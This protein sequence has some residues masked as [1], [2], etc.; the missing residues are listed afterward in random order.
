VGK[1]ECFTGNVLVAWNTT[2]EVAQPE[3]NLN[4]GDI[5]D[6]G[7][8]T[9]LYKGNANSALHSNLLSNETYYYSVW[10]ILN[11][12]Y[13]SPLSFAAKTRCADDIITLPY[14]DTIGPF[15][16]SGCTLDTMSFR[17]FTAGPQPELK[18]VE[19][20]INP[21]AIPFTGGYMLQFNAYDT[22]ET[23]EVWLTTGHL[24]SKG[25]AS[26]DV[27]FK[28]YEDASDYTGEFF[29]PEGVTLQWSVDYVNW[30]HVVR[31]PRITEYGNDGWKYKQVTL[32]SAAANSDA[33][34]IRFVFTSAWGFNCYLDEI[35]VIPT[36]PKV[37]DNNI[38]TAE[39]QFT[40]PDGSTHYYDEAERLLL[41]IEASNNL[42]DHVDEG[43]E[44]WAG[45]QPG[46]TL[47]PATDNYVRNA[48]GWATIGKYWSLKNSTALSEPLLVKQYVSTGDIEM[49]RQL[50]A[51]SFSPLPV[52]GDSLRLMAYFLQN[53]NR[54]QADPALGHT[55]I[56]FAL[57][58]GQAGFWQYDI[59]AQTD[60]LRFT[61]QSFIPGWMAV[62][63]QVTQWG[64]GGLGVGSKAGNGALLP[65]WVN[66]T[67][68]RQQKTT[69]LNWTTGY[70]REWLLMQVERKAVTD[71]TF[72][73]IGFLSPVGWSQS[74]AA[75]S[76]TDAQMLP[77]G[78]YSYRVRATDIRGK[79][80]LSP[81]T[82]IEVSEVKGLLLFPNPANRG[83]LMIFGETTMEWLRII[84]GM[85][86]VVYTA[87]P[88]STQ[89]SIDLSHLAAGIYYV[90]AM[91]PV[92]M[93]VQKLLINP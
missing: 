48:G 92:G 49:L 4:A 66:I 2:G 24:S 41:S 35:A 78:L 20:G 44:L 5:F 7:K 81:E 51:S 46:A 9:V 76:F 3:G 16:L 52:P 64:G 30:S 38:S 54:A 56:S 84:D 27:A 88:S 67:A 21:S 59:G 8:A 72:R 17:N 62:S 89:Y 70:E 61:L 53:V 71:N 85:G 28:W 18:V 14:R 10:P 58:Y 77:N 73:D 23:N 91:M 63:Q 60:S 39:A 32:P 47:L 87:K 31:Y 13:G 42:L 82:N 86:R 65:H 43:L 69:N 26:V 74:G 75:Y 68:S 12:V 6:G 33:L 15:S 19:Q 80:Y 55:G 11:G 29:K 90:Q 57:Q 45:G 79:E 1:N 37:S 93:Q 50:A 22:R 25:I 83:R 36:A 34:Y 40:L